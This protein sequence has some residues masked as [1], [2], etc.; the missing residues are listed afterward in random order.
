M[1][2]IRTPLMLA[3]LAGV[4]AP[5]LADAPV[6]TPA[7]EINPVDT[8]AAMLDAAYRTG[9]DATIRSVIGV[10]KATFPD[11]GVEIDRL[12]AGDAAVVAATR[13]E[14]E[15]TANVGAEMAGNGC[16]VIF[17]WI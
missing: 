2:V 12:A 1:P 14:R 6:Q 7:R 9:D 16:R 17:N 8:I 5:A 15:K 11:Q 3:L 4:A 10:A 13:K